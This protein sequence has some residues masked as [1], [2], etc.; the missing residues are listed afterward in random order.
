MDRPAA[1]AIGLFT[2]EGER[3]WVPGWDPAY[4]TE[5]VSESPGTVFTTAVG[6][7]ET[8]WV[9]IEIDRPAG[10]SAYARITPGRH[11][12]TVSV[13]CSES[14]ENTCEVAVSYDMTLLDGADPTHMTPYERPAFEGMLEE[15]SDMI[16]D[17]LS[18]SL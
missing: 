11:A 8:Y 1:Q 13:E 3:Q 12:G 6:D 2:P 15:W 18:A 4:A 17:H 5:D 16:V 9:I 10:R 7:V 14:G